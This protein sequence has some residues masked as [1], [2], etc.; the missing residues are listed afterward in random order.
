MSLSSSL[1]QPVWNSRTQMVLLSANLDQI[2]AGQLST[3]WSQTLITAATATGRLSRQ[4][5]PTRPCEHPHPHRRHTGSP[6]CQSAHH[7]CPT[8][9]R[10]VQ[11]PHCRSALPSSP[12]S[13]KLKTVSL[14]CSLVCKACLQQMPGLCHSRT[15]PGL[16]SQT[17]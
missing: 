7:Y 2:L 8:G 10:T 11:V 5:Q 9:V 16:S 13:H 3:S 1:P 14:D 4:Q 15:T 12:L 17:R 6:P